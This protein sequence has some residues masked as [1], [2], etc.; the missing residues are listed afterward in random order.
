MFPRS[1]SLIRL[2]RQQVNV[3]K[4]LQKDM[5]VMARANNVDKHIIFITYLSI[6][7]K[8]QTG[9]QFS[10]G[11]PIEYTTEGVRGGG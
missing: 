11:Q 6:S 7:D 4:K 1:I 2:G 3:S 10:N 5:R 9:G 8:T